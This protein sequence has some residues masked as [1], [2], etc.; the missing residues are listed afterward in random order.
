MVSG[1]ETFKSWFEGYSTRYVIIGGTACNLI[2]SEYGAPERATHDID[3]VVVAEA[4][5]R[6]FYNRFVEFVKAGGYKHKN[7]AEKYELYRFEAPDDASFPPKIE[8]LSKRP[9]NLQGIETELG[10]FQT[11]D[12]SGSL[13]AILLDDEY[14]DLLEDGIVEI[15]GLPVLSLEYLPVFKIHAWANLSDDKSAGKRISSDEINKHRR[16]VL[17]LCSLFA[18]GAHIELPESM[19]TEIVRFI[20]ERPWDDNMMRNLKL[21]IS[22]DEMAEIIRSIYL[23]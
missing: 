19:Q 6:E 15:D 11:M 10:R 12:A 20:E 8:L 2:Y 9:E 3:M 21:N 22:A 17:R 13:S 16:D 7:K 5:D 1:L 14:Y 23:S 4:F 18:P